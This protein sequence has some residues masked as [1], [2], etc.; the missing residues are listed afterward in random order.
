MKQL[1]EYRKYYPG[2]DGL[3]SKNTTRMKHV[4]DDLISS[5]GDHHVSSEVHD[6]FHKHLKYLNQIAARIKKK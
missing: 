2:K 1:D 4:I 5:N 3:V 6:E